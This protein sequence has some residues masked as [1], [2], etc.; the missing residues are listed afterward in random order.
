MNEWF[1]IRL[2]PKQVELA[3]DERK[4]F[5]LKAEPFQILSFP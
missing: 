1:R 3:L 2:L 4:Y 5:Q